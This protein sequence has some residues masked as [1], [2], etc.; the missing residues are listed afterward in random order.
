MAKSLDAF[1]LHSQIMADYRLFVDSFVNIKDKIIRKKV[2]DEMAGGKFWPEPLL[3]FNPAFESGDSVQ[4]LCS[5]GVLNPSIQDIFSGFSLFKHQVEAIRIG[6]QGKDFVI[7][8]GTGSGKSLTF[9][10]TI[11][12]HL[13]NNGTGTGIKA[14]IV[15]PMNESV[16]LIGFSF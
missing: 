4:D 5:E 1:Q 15:Y 8:S 11:F 9:L 10:G 12:N 6:S 14:V 7:T 13:L 2:E 16:D 3:Q